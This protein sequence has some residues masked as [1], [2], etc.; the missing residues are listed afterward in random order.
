[1]NPRELPEPCS[2]VRDDS[3]AEDETARLESVHRD[4]EEVR[5]RSPQRDRLHA[6]AAA[7]RSPHAWNS[8]GMQG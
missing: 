3:I 6:F 5:S 7:N 4:D 2:R 8:P 1:M